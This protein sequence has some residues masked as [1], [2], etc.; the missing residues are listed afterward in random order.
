MGFTYWLRYCSEV[1]HRRPTKL[2]TMFG[3]PL[4]WYTIYTFSGTLAL[5][6]ILPGAKFTLRPSLVFFYIGSVTAWHLRSGLQ[7]NCGVV[8]SRDR[9]AIP[10]DIE[11]SNCLVHD[12]NDNFC[13]IFVYVLRSSCALKGSIVSFCIL[14]Q[15]TYSCTDDCRIV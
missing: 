1:A 4:S 2:C 5:A 8:S 15:G 12:N 14:I 10:F 3:S 13:D 9:A 7:P 11:Q 6:R